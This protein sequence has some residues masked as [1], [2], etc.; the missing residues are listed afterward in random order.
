MIYIHLSELGNYCKSSGAFDW[1][2][3]SWLLKPREERSWALCIEPPFFILIIYVYKYFILNNHYN[4]WIIK[5]LLFLDKIIILLLFIRLYFN[6]NTILIIYIICFVAFANI[7]TAVVFNS[8]TYLIILVIYWSKYLKIL[9][10]SSRYLKKKFPVTFI[11]LLPLPTI[12]HPEIFDNT[13]FNNCNIFYIGVTILT[14][15]P[16]KQNI[17]KIKFN[18]TK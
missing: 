18:I 5:F 17:N 12:P 10:S 15:L 4:H 2:S 7:T 6:D 16:V 13:I 1:P 8:P 14:F 9:N 3:C 11:A